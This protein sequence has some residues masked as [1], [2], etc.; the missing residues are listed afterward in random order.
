M[1]TIRLLLLILGLICF[2][3][4]AAGVQSRIGLQPLGLAFWITTVLL[5]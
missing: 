3:L 4:A 2:I 1:I 5:G